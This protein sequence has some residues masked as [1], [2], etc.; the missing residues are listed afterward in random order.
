[1]SVRLVEKEKKGSRRSRLRCRDIMTSNVIAANQ[2]MNLREVAAL[3]RDGD[4][5][6][7]PVIDENKKLVGI[8][9]DRDIVIRG[10][11]AGKVSSE[12]TASE[13]MTTEIHTAQPETPVFQ[14]IR[15]MGDKQ[16]R[17]VPIVDENGILQGILAIADIALEL[18]DEREIAEAL[19]DISSGSAFW[20]KN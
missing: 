4:I 19:E 7:L 13:V 1:M 6:S 14:V 20:K 17:R 3:M 8:L 12:T 2:T 9:T 15:L 18:E 16:V 11:A 5:G 10:V